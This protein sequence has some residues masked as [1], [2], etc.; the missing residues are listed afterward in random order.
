[1]I[2]RMGMHFHICAV[3]SVLV[4]VLFVTR[5]VLSEVVDYH[6]TSESFV[7]VCDV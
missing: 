2:L 1:M 7:Q 6:K 5:L 3:S 4:E